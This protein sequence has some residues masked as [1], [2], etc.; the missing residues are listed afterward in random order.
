MSKNYYDILGVDKNANGDEIKS[1]FKKQAM[2]YHPDRNKAPE[3]E[4]KFKE[5]NEA[6]EV[7]G[8]AGK[9]K[10]Y[11]QFGSAEGMQ[12]GFGGF[13]NFYQQGDFNG[14]G[15]FGFDFS[16]IFEFMNGGRQKK[17]TQPD[18]GKDIEYEMTISLEE[19]F[20]GKT[21]D[22]EYYKM[23]MCNICNGTC[24]KGSGQSTCAIC[25]GTGRT[26]TVKGFAAIE[27]TCYG[28]KGT[29]ISSDSLCGGC[30]GEGRLNKKTK[31]SIKIPSGIED[32]KKIRIKN[33]GDAGIRG[34]PNGDFLLYINVQKHKT[35]Q[36]EGQNLHTKINV[37]LIDALLGGSMNIK[38]IDGNDVII[39]IPEELQNNSLIV[40]NGGGMPQ[41]NSSNRGDL[42]CHCTIQMPKKLNGEQKE[43]I[44][45]ALSES[46]SSWTSKF[47]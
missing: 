22:I 4:S 10:N 37:N 18:K 34:G 15:G 8:D 21:V 30:K 24:V 46:S 20:S 29:G 13:D 25:H 39:K 33:D 45:K 38:G 7:L 35:F 31:L 17:S 12:G 14:G 47:F 3:A 11:D 41:L 6:Y 23:Q 43:L 28:C 1:A 36:V 16:E 2:K 27:R 32:G 42:I 5:I 26:R 40:V 9:R 44:K 19:A